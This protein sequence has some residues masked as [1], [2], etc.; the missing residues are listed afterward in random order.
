[1]IGVQHQL[2]EVEKRNLEPDGYQVPSLTRKANAGLTRQ[3][4]M[5]KGAE[6]SGS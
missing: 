6:L 3:A 2:T 5:S 4:E 1:M